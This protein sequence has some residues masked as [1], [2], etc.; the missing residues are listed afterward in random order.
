MCHLGI[1][2][3]STQKRHPPF[4]PTVSLTGLH[5]ELFPPSVHFFHRQ[6]SQN[7]F[8]ISPGI[9]P[10]QAADESPLKY[11]PKDRQVQRHLLQLSHENR[12]IH[13][14]GQHQPWWIQVRLGPVFKA[15]TLSSG[16]ALTQM[17]FRGQWSLMMEVAS[18]WAPLY[19]WTPPSSCT[20]SKWSVILF[21]RKLF[22]VKILLLW[23]RM[24]IFP[25]A[26]MESR[27]GK[28]WMQTCHIS[29]SSFIKLLHFFPGNQ[30]SEFSSDRIP[31]W[32][33]SVRLGHFLWLS[34]P[35]RCPYKWTSQSLTIETGFS[36]MAAKQQASLD[37]MRGTLYILHRIWGICCKFNSNFSS[38]PLGEISW[39]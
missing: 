36:F 14:N 13:R 34:H 29:F 38:F 33:T 30:L 31:L 7:N 23:K 37:K 5:V 16:I 28:P 24:G 19:K 22:G 20:V 15:N 11:S 32:G 10:R 27:S 18:T 25:L 8:L 21:E 17:L 2:P 35:L 4:I 39:E 6:Q 3:S 26:F 1:V 12:A 9:A